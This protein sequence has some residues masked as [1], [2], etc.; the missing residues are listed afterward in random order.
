MSS[1]STYMNAEGDASLVAMETESGSCVVYWLL[2]FDSYNFFAWFYIHTRMYTIVDMLLSHELL[3]TIS[4][5]VCRCGYRS[6]FHYPV[7]FLFSNRF[8]GTTPVKKKKA[9]LKK[10]RYKM[11]SSTQ[12][13]KTCRVCMRKHNN[14]QACSECMVSS[15]MNNQDGLAQSPWLVV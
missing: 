11:K 1:D 7:Y 9:L 15:I 12:H 5:L 3:N 6:C 13:K 8:S 4:S 10:Q 14:I 2:Q